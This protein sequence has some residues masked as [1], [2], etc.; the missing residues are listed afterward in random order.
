MSKVLITG[1]VGFIGTNS[2][3]YFSENNWYVSVVD[4]F[5]REGVEINTH[6]LA[7]NYPEIKIV[8]TD[9]ADINSY[10]QQIKQADLIIHLA[11]QTAVTKSV[12]DPQHDFDN[13]LVA[14]IALLEA[15][16]QNNP[17]AV[18]LFS[19]TNKVY[20]DLAHHKFKKDSFKKRYLD[21]SA[22]KG[23][24]EDERLSF[25]SPYGCSKGALDQYF[26]DYARI[27]G[28]KTVVFRQSCIYGPHQMG[29]EDQGWVAH[30]S[31]QILR[32]QKITIY[33]DG[34]QV[35]DLL[36][37]DDLTKLYL[38]AYKQITKVA[39]QVF[40]VGGGFENS[41]SLLEVLDYLAKA[42]YKEPKI[43]F[44]LTRIGD[45]PF[46]VSDNFKAKKMLN[47]QPTTSFRGGLPKLIDWQKLNLLK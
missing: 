4:N 13:N 8:K 9:V 11:G 6:F 28:L 25:I 26:L 23:V 2:T 21:L 3:A 47:W 1:G 41:F 37:V 43:S 22:P 39:G 16:R 38:E 44:D 29:V 10:L 36:F 18:V 42:T 35:R 40:N 30:F 32:N 12:N 15:V 5:S 34:F 20:G 7:K 17:K 46:F 24:S 33:G 14:G 31:K 45:Q 27:Y 19:S